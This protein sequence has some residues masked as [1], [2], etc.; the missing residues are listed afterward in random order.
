MID[1][2]LRRLE[3]TV[4]DPIEDLRAVPGAD[5][6]PQKFAEP[7]DIVPDEGRSPCRML[8]IEGCVDRRAGPQIVQIRARP[9]VDGFL[10]NRFVEIAN[11]RRVGPRLIRR[12][13][14]LPFSAVDHGHDNGVLAGRLDL[15]P[16]L[17][18]DDYGV[19]FT[20]GVK[21]CE[22]EVDALRSE[23]NLVLDSD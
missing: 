13:R 1:K 11:Q 14:N 20:V 9:Q 10:L 22:D 3:L 16:L 17:Q 12:V 21:A 7:L 4:V 8:V 2:A 23:W 5:V 19:L 6:A 15:R 18:L